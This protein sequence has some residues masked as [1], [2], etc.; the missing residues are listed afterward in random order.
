[1]DWMATGVG[2]IPGILGL[3]WNISKS[4]RDNRTKLEIDVRFAYGF[5]TPDLRQWSD[6]PAPPGYNR[7]HQGIEGRVINRGDKDVTLDQAFLLT[8][9]GVIFNEYFVHVERS[10]TDD[11]NVVEFQEFPVVLAPGGY[12]D[13]SDLG[14]EP[15]HLN[16]VDTKYRLKITTTMGKRKTVKI[17]ERVMPDE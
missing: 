5:A 4:L 17:R 8:R 16:M 12:Y 6:E 3:G 7:V 11:S 14:I 13:L 10:A 9:S 15:A 2:A 1:M